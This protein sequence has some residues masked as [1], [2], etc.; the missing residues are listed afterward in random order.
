MIQNKDWYKISLKSLLRHKFWTSSSQLSIQRINSNN[1]KFKRTFIQA[2][3]V[4]S[5]F[6]KN[7]SFTLL[8]KVS[9]T[10]KPSQVKE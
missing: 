3:K 5:N 1:N 8:N 6:S 9:S 2:I 10:Q 7:K 4:N